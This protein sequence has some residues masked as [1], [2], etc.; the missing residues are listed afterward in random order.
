VITLPLLLVLLA[1]IFAVLAGAFT[2]GWTR[3]LAGAV[4]LI[5]IVL[6]MGKV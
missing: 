3:V 6:L 5:C 2:E 1:F 4:V